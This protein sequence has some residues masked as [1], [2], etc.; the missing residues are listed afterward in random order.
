MDRKISCANPHSIVSWV[1]QI[2][3]KVIEMS[4]YSF[5]ASSKIAPIAVGFA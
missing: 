1:T 5:M 4:T 2:V 3:I